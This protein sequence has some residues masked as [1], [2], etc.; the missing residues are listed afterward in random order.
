MLRAHSMAAH[1]ELSLDLVTNR[2]FTLATGVGGGSN[3]RSGSVGVVTM[4]TLLFEKA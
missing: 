3:G 2:V 1:V 4:N